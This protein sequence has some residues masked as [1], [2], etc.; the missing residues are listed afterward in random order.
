MFPAWRAD[1]AALANQ[2]SAVLALKRWLTGFAACVRRQDFDRAREFFRLDAYCFGSYA[3]ACEDRET[4]IEQQWR[5][6]WPNITDFGFELSELRYQI[7]ADG[8][9]ASAMV[10]WHSVGYGSDG[11]A[12]QRDGRVTLVLTRADQRQPWQ[13]F[14]THYSLVPGTP[15]TAI[16]RASRSS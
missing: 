6:I 14:H 12:F 5:K 11:V 13:A 15:Q 16:R 3:S 2:A 1:G 4:L 9:L 8:L 10:P 7:S